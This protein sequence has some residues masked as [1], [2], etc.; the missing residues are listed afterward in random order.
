[1][2]TGQS[3]GNVVGKSNRPH[4]KSRRPYLWVDKNCTQVRRQPRQIPRRKPR[5]Q[6]AGQRVRYRRERLLGRRDDILR[7]ADGGAGG[8]GHHCR[9]Q[10]A[11][12]SVVCGGDVNG[13]S[14]VADAAEPA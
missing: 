3:T 5:G 10:L 1:M 4:R 9:F 7:V 14:V 13:V 12:W 6:K 2:E 11:P 8:L